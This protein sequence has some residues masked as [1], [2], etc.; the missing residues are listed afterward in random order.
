MLSVGNAPKKLKTQS[1]KLKRSSL[2]LLDLL[3]GPEPLVVPSFLSYDLRVRFIGM[4]MLRNPDRGMGT[5]ESRLE[6]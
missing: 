1:S 4:F 3:T 5:G 2:F 6:A